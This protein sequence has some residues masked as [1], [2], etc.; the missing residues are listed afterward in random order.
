MHVVHERRVPASGALSSPVWRSQEER[1]WGYELL[2]SQ[3]NPWHDRHPWYSEILKEV[4]NTSMQHPSLLILYYLEV[5]GSMETRQVFP[6]ERTA[7]V[8]TTY[9]A[10]FSSARLC[11]LL[12]VCQ[13]FI[14]TCVP[15]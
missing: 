7:L 11:C 9:C 13:S 4:P 5:L 3:A 2:H 1:D 10:S 6:S 14:E 12:F 8:V 15:S